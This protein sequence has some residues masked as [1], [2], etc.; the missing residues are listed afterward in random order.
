MSLIPSWG[1]PNVSSQFETR[2]KALFQEL[3]RRLMEIGEGFTAIDTNVTFNTNQT[4]V[5]RGMF[6]G[7]S[8]WVVG[9]TTVGATDFALFAWVGNTTYTVALAAAQ[10]YPNMIVTIKKVTA[11]NSVVIAGTVD[12]ASSLT[13]T[14]LNSSYVLMA[15]SSTWN[16]LAN[17]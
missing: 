8:R 1:R 13:L 16:V 5:F 3:V 15:S 6:G 14:T 9:T 10:D 11:L 4:S 2:I 12:G 7:P 17:Y